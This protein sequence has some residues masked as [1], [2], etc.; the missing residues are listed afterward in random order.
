MQ[1][2]KEA[3]SSTVDKLGAAA[4]S[5]TST[6]KGDS[7]TGDAPQTGAEPVVDTSSVSP[8]IERRNSLQKQLENRPDIQDLKNRNILLDTTAAPSVPP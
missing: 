3:V 1:A 5:V 4:S 2:I 8:T 7:A 6:G